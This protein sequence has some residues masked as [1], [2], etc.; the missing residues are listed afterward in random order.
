MNFKIVKAGIQ[1]ADAIA[2]VIQKVYESLEQKEWYVADN[3]EYTF[4]MLH[5]KKGIGYMAL[6][7]ENNEIAGIFMV[8][9]PGDSKE[10][11][12]NDIGFSR[13]QRLLSAH[14]DSAAVLPQ[15]RGHH[16]QYR[17]MQEA[18]KDLRALGFRYLLCT[19]HPDNR[20]SKNNALRQGYCVMKTTEKYGGYLRDVLMKELT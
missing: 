19:I 8:T 11:L 12:G 3:A 6:N 1:D 15:Y 17:L 9:F 18:E 16:L 7:M 4:E 20:Y 10:N 14:M 13:E 5:S 2:A